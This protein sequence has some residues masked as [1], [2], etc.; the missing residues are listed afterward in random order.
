MIEVTEASDAGHALWHKPR[1]GRECPSEVGCIAWQKQ[2]LP[3]QATGRKLCDG[4]HMTRG[5]F[6]FRITSYFCS[7]QVKW[8]GSSRIQ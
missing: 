8:S 7:E 6:G 5:F 4:D 1:H 2:V 3:E